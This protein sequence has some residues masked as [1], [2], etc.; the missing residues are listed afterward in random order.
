MPCLLGGI[1]GA[2]SIAILVVLFIYCDDL[3]DGN[4]G[5]D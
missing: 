2:L 4:V 1:I 5:S 3:E